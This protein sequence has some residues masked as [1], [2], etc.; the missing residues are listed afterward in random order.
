M[1]QKALHRTSFR[2]FL[3]LYPLAALRLCVNPSSFDFLCV[4]S[5]VSSGIISQPEKQQSGRPHGGPVPDCF[6]P[7][8]SLPHEAD[9]SPKMIG[10]VTPASARLH[11]PNQA[12]RLYHKIGCTFIDRRMRL[13]K[14]NC[15]GFSAADSCPSPPILPLNW[16]LRFCSESVTITPILRRIQINKS[17]SPRGRGLG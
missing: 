8:K 1:K 10:I 12:K 14:G 9:N 6:P 15:E 3:I 4:P 7:G 13:L 5:S 16:P 11:S 17:P 2:H